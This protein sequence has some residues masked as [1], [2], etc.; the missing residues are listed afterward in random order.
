MPRLFACVVQYVTGHHSDCTS[1]SVC[2]CVPPKCGAI[3]V[4]HATTSSRCLAYGRFRSST[5]L[6]KYC[7]VTLCTVVCNCNF[8]IKPC[9]HS[10]LAAASVTCPGRQH[11]RCQCKLPEIE[12]RSTQAGLHLALRL[13]VHTNSS[14]AHTVLQISH[15]VCVVCWCLCAIQQ[16]CCKMWRAHVWWYEAAAAGVIY[17]QVTCQ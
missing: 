1:K 9:F 7:V 4:L 15:C 12:H 3:H 13:A 5:A 11:V 14:A 2:V 8:T 17:S 10:Y 6:K 16:E